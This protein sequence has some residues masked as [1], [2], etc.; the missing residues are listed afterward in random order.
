MNIVNWQE[1]EAGVYSSGQ[2]MPGD[3][4]AIA[5]LGVKTVVNL[6]PLMETGEDEA[7]AVEA[8]GMKYVYI[9]VNGAEE[10]T[11]ENT[12]LLCE[13][14]QGRDGGILVHCASGNR[15]GALYA[16]AA[17]AQGKSV[18][19]A[20]AYGLRGGLTRLQDTVEQLLKERAK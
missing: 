16:L 11:P 13:T 10:L 12:R 18:P 9:P 17:Q 6:R 3:W 8:Q 14:L 15:C 20:L 2:P 5:E 4:Q 19:E 1:V 7:P